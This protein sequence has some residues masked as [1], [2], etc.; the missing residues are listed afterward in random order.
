MNAAAREEA[1]A[2]KNRKEPNRAQKILNS[3]TCTLLRKKSQQLS[4]S[5]QTIKRHASLKQTFSEE[6]ERDQGESIHETVIVETRSPQLSIL[7]SD[8][9]ELDEEQKTNTTTLKMVS[10]IGDLG[11]GGHLYL[12]KILQK[13]RKNNKRAGPNKSVQAGILL[14]IKKACMHAYSGH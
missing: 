3:V 9:E 8:E 5:Q 13:S 11:G 1:E 2:S 7:L 12:T 14:K 10:T 6:F 4:Q